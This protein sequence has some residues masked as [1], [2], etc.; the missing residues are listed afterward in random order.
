MVTSG[1]GL[2]M[3][4]DIFANRYKRDLW[5]HF[6]ERD[7]KFLTQTFRIIEEELFPG[8]NV[9]SKAALTLIHDKLATELGQTELSPKTYVYNYS[10]VG[11]HPIDVVCRNFVCQ[12]YEGSFAD[13]WM[14]ERLSF[15]ELAF[16][17]RAAAVDVESAE[18][19]RRV[20]TTMNESLAGRARLL[21]G[22]RLPG[23]PAEGLRA[24]KEQ[25]IKAFEGAVLEFNTRLQQAVTT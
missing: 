13:K 9:K 19:D 8:A 10:E 25:K 1:V 14:K 21:S 4:T 11:L 5:T 7:R 15:I 24:Q 16:R 17:E 23:K 12:K 22:V 20:G 2:N 18:L 6:E 3:L